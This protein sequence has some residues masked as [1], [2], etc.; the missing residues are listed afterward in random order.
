MIVLDL[1]LEMIGYTTARIVLP[2]V[3]FGKMRVERI[4]STE[5][6]FSWFGF[7]RAPDGALLCQVSMAGWIGLIPWILAVAV[8]VTVPSIF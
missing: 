5:V 8:I 3:T 2:L 4:S 7:K 6:G 1:I